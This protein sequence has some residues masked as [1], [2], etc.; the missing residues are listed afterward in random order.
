MSR[1]VVVVPLPG[2]SRKEFVAPSLDTRISKPR[3][4]GHRGTLFELKEHINVD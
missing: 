3:Q 4:R 1:F 2:P